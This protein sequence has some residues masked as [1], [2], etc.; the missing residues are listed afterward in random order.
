MIS[1]STSADLVT[2]YAKE[3]HRMDLDL[4]QA[5]ETRIMTLQH[6]V[7]AEL[8]EKGAD[9]RTIA[10]LRIR[11]V[12]EQL[13]PPPS[14]APSLPAIA[15]PGNPGQPTQVSVTFNAE[16]IVYTA[17]E[18]I[19][20]TANFGS[21]AKE[22][23]ALINQYGGLNAGLLRTALHEVE[24]PG[25]PSRLRAEAKRRLKSFLADLAR[26]LPGLGVDLLE[27][28]LERQLGLPSS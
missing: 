20:G 26:Q 27:K 16:H 1:E 22:V 28:Y 3:Y 10:S 6:T 21:Q 18:N 17:V 9:P 23:L 19:Q 11:S 12:L 15:A 2:K 13:V 25:V 14:A 4:R 8:L 5:R 24:D 7:E